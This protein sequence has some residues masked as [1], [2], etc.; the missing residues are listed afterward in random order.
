LVAAAVEQANDS[1]SSI[2]SGHRSSSWQETEARTTLL[3]SCAR[4][5]SGGCTVR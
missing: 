3:A 1:F 5:W 2:Q 4:A